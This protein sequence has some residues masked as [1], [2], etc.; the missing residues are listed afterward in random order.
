MTRSAH[1][2]TFTR[3]NL[4]P[5]E[6][7]PDFL[8]TLPELQYPERLNAV[9]ELLDAWLAKGH[10]EAP[11]IH[12][13]GESWTYADL[14]ER[15]NRIANV[16][17]KDLGMVPGGR[18]LLRSANTPML[19]AAYLAILKAGGVVVATMPLLRARELAYPIRKAR[20]ELA[21]CDAKLLTDR[22]EAHR[23]LGRWLANRAGKPDGAGVARIRGRG[24]GRG[25]LLP[26][27]VYVGHN[28]RAQGHDAQPPRPARR[29]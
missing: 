6:L 25:G 16:L 7:Q 15:V 29:V 5:P 18:V 27:W 20:V 3:D 13:T 28:R 1:L 14:A 19:V 11:C 9:T 8:F 21:L 26:D 2:D 10:G 24:H 23:D 17:V 22:P 4:P 12:A